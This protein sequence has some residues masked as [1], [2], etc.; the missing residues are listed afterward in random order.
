MVGVSFNGRLGN[1][2]FQFYFLLYLKSRKKNCFYFF[3]NPHHTKLAKY[4][5][6]GFYYH[7]TLG[8]KIYSVFTRILPRLIRF[9]DIYI[10]NIEV[11]KK[12]DVQN[13][14][15]YRGFFQTD[16]YLKHTP[17]KFNIR[18]RQKYQDEFQAL[19][20]DIFKSEKTMAVHI[21]RTDYLKYG[22]RDISLPIEYFKRQLAAIS[23]K[24]DYRIFFLSDDIEYVK[25]EFETKPNYIF[26]DNS[27]IIDFQIIKNADL[28][29]IS[30]SSFSWWA[31]YLSEKKNTVIAP[32]NWLAFR[33]GKEH[34]KGVMTEK[35][36]WKDVFHD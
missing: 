21:R 18:I 17:E 10:Q 7:L 14:T 31:C 13:F 33:L 29:I 25:A 4:F 6:L 5:D 30:N 15:I 9:K 2:L 20:G 35:F 12:V 8:S 23:N 1:Q 32:K 24:D 22:K 16:W 26:S 36:I 19:Y 11:P 27:E 34:P 3:P 28:A